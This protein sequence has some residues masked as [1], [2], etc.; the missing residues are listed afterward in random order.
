MEQFKQKSLENQRRNQE[1]MH[2]FQLE[3]GE[4]GNKRRDLRDG[5]SKISTLGKLRIRQLLQPGGEFDLGQRAVIER[6][7]SV[8][9]LDDFGQALGND[10]SVAA[11]DG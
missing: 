1:R 10:L 3:W 7:D 9:V 4:Q 2:Q 8:R 6:L 5:M 11:L